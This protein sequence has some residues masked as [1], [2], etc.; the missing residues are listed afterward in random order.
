MGAPY[1]FWVGSNVGIGTSVGQIRVN[2][3][4]EKSEVSYDL[5]HSYEEGGLYTKYTLHQTGLYAIGLDTLLVFLSVPF[6]VEEKSGV[7]TIIDELSK[8]NRPLYDFEA[9]ALHDNRNMTIV[10]NTTI[11]VVDVNDERGVLLK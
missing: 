1:E 8:Y 10:T 11:H 2:D 9:V 6:A 3:A 4:M 5:L 7:I